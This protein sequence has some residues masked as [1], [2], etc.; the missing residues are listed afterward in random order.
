MKNLK[1]LFQLII[2][3]TIIIILIWKIE[4]GNILGV[5]AGAKISYIIL[6]V[7]IAYVFLFLGG[8]TIYILLKSI[9]Y[10][11][12]FKQIIKGYMKS[13]PLSL[14]GLGKSGEFSIL[15]FLKDKDNNI[16]KISAVFLVD[17]LL[18]F[19]YLISVSII[20]CF[21]YFENYTTNLLWMVIGILFIILI[22]AGVRSEKLREIIR[23]YILRKYSHKMGNFYKTFKILL[24]NKK[25]LLLNFLLTVVRWVLSAFITFIVFKSIGHELGLIPIIL[26]EPLAL[27]AGFIPISISGLGVRES[28]AIILFSTLLGVDPTVVFTVY[29]IKFTINAF[30]AITLVPVLVRNRD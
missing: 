16:G 5:L 9:K 4:I 7:V 26:I 8:F 6:S 12:S 30:M 17:K 3:L 10:E 14:V 20:A 24:K 11:K 13:W 15:Y 29:M 18:T 25:M 1:K 19:I 28:V 23:S 2:G 21:Y 27:L 22:V